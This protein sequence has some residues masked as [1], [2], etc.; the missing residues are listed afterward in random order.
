MLP[1]LFPSTAPTHTFSLHERRYA[2][3]PL[4]PARA[5]APQ[6]DQTSLHLL[7]V[8][9]PLPPNLTAT[10]PLYTFR[11]HGGDPRGSCLAVLLALTATTVAVVGALILAARTGTP[12]IFL[13]LNA[14]AF[15]LG[16]FVLALKLNQSGRW[17]PLEIELDTDSA[18]IRCRERRSGTVRWERPINP[19]HI[20]IS[21]LKLRRGDAGKP[22]MALVH[23]DDPHTP[24]ED[25]E[26]TPAHTVLA[27]GLKAPLFQLAS[28][29]QARTD[30]TLAQR[31]GPGAVARTESAVQPEP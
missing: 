2:T 7:T 11:V 13:M 21:R 5:T 17:A 26:P 14:A 16:A 31:H 29:L 27:S 3:Y 30:A 15:S 19:D 20:Y 9:T 22:R 12:D 1:C 10:P 4:Q 8:S 6:P 18:T 28:E 24:V 23:G 25:G